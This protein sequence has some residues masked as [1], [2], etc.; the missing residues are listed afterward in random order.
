MDAPLGESMKISLSLKP[1][2]LSSSWLLLVSFETN[3]KLCILKE[4]CFNSMLKNVFYPLE[5]KN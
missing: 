2:A 1:V 5:I 4:N 3:L